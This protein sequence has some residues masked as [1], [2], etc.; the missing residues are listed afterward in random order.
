MNDTI[1]FTVTVKNT[2]NYVGQE[3]IQ[4]YISDKKSSLLR[5]VKELKAF[6]KIRLAPGEE[7]VVAFTIGKEALSFF[8]DTKHEWVA[9]PGKF[10]AL[11]GSSS[12][13]IR[14]TVRFE[15]K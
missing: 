9:E 3:V 2:G 8:D 7:K 10:E 12:R 11:F 6:K 4:L 1:T 15:L 5:P 13:D 14:G